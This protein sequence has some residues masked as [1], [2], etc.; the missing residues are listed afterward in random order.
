MEWRS[1]REWYIAMGVIPFAAYLFV[2]GLIMTGAAPDSFVGCIVIA[3]ATVGW[4]ILD[5]YFLCVNQHIEHEFIGYFI[6]AILIA[7]PTWFATRQAP[8]IMMSAIPMG[9]YQTGSDVQGIRW[10]GEYL[11]L[12][13]SLINQTDFDYSNVRIWVRTNLV[14]AKIAF[15]GENDCKA[16]PEL[17][18]LEITSATIS[19]TDSRGG[20]TSS[21]IFSKGQDVVAT[22]FAVQ[23]D[24]FI[25]HSQIEMAFAALRW[26]PGTSGTVEWVAV[27]ARYFGGYK[28]RDEFLTKCLTGKCA[29]LPQNRREMAKAA[30][31]GV[32]G[33]VP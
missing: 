26:P 19:R 32:Y 11:P 31:M 15:A 10:K 33:V 14:I 28:N 6:V 29:R 23:C 8:L 24:K 5:W 20:V 27:S 1:I 2:V 17:P 13:A 9:N 25:A 30:H 16:E 7:I 12:D 21:R 4:L 3:Y 22:V 18:G